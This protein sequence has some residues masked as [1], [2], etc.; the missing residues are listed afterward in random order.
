M[1]K[2]KY[3][4]KHVQIC[5]VVNGVEMGVLKD[6]TPFLSMRGLAE[7][8]GVAPGNL[9]KTATGWR[10]GDPSATGLG[11]FLIRELSPEDPLHIIV[12]GPTGQ[13]Y[14]FTDKVSHLIIQHYAFEAKI[15]KAQ[16]TLML[17]SRAG[18]AFFIYTSIGYDPR[19]IVP[20]PWRQFHDRMSIVSSPRGYWSVFKECSELVLRAIRSG[21][22]VNEHTV[23][24]ISVGKTWSDYWQKENLVTLGERLHF[25]H[26]YPDYFAQSA[27]NPQDMWVYPDA[28]LGRFRTWF[29]STYVDEK[30]DKYLSHKVADG[31]LP[32]QHAKALLKQSGSQAE[33]KKLPPKKKR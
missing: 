2:S 23:P 27:S 32:E 18:I 13:Q 31:V 28:A 29:S 11:R 22:P 21:L 26:N 17:I 7:L 1:K 15:D 14:A 25:E 10:A 12:P 16:D 3:N 30:F 9:S 24:D 20:E 5:K 6:G 33:I 19:Y 4:F 8:C